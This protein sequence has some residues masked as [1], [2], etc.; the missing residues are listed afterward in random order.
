MIVFALTGF[1][2][3]ANWTF[4]TW[5]LVHGLALIL[6]RLFLKDLTLRRKSSRFLVRFWTV[7]VV[8]FGWL[9]FRA[10]NLSHAGEMLIALKGGSGFGLSQIV[11]AAIT[12]QRV[13]WTSVGLTTFFLSTKQSFG[14]KLID[15]TSHLVLRSTAVLA[16]LLASI[17]VL[18]SSFSPFLYF[19]F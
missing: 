12:P 2:H 7:L 19:Q 11:L 14:E 1:W 8:V 4:L 6:E 5:G 9:F 16:G 17:Y 10:D 15:G 3:G 13:F 18:S